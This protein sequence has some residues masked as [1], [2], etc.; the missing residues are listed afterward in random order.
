V[1]L[2]TVVHPILAESLPGVSTWQPGILGV[3]GLALGI[4]SLASALLPAWRLSRAE[5]ARHLS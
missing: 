1:V 3:S 5:P 2:G 4:V